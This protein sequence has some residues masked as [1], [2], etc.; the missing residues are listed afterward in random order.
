MNQ[1][2]TS[3]RA[4]QRCQICD[5]V[6]HACWLAGDRARDIA[7]VLGCSR[8]AVIGRARRLGLSHKKPAPRRPGVIAIAAGRR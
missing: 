8:N 1:R 4:E 5:S 3:W 2:S 6:I 7:G